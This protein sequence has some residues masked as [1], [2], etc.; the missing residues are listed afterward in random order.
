MT[1]GSRIAAELRRAWNDAPWHG[2]SLAQV[3]GRLGAKQAAARR[4]RGS[5]T[6]WELVLHL[7]V[8]VETP[9]RR[10]DDPSYDPPV[11]FPEPS[12]TPELH[13][14][15]DV[16]RL[17]D[18]IETLAEHVERMQDAELAA[19]VGTRGYS[20]ATMFDGVAQ[21]LAY[22]AGQIAVL[23]LNEEVAGVLLPPPLIGIGVIVLAEVLGRAFGAHFTRPGWLGWVLLAAGLGLFG[24]THEYFAKHRTPAAPWRAARTL[25]R[26]GPFRLTRNPMY[27]GALL[28][29]AGIGC[30]RSNPL[31]IILLVPAWAVLHWG[32]VLREERYLLKRFGAPYQQF[33]DSTRRWF[34]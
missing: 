2:P 32:V 6:P 5:H 17:G 29:L 26:G 15:Q 30:L 16:D 8:W 23:A 14:A 7:T 24:W 18:A 9:L 3:V 31:Y 20:Y 28:I 13:W 27:V 25:M 4:A 19:F 21:H 22:H 33:M 10:V 12:P 1:Q 34:S 11:D